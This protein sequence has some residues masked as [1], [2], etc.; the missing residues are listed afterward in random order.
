MSSDPLETLLEGAF[1]AELAGSQN[2]S[3]VQQILARIERRQ[4]VRT[5]VFAGLATVLLALATFT[6]QPLLELFTDW[7]ATP[8][9][10]AGDWAAT[11]AGLAPGL[12]LLAVIALAPWLLALLDD[13][14]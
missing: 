14:V 10:A 4:R 9:A 3:A 8:D 12:P 6:A 13:R 2:P 1:R 5:L 11:L 7:L